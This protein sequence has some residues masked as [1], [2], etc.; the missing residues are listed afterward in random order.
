MVTA[1]RPNGLQ[2]FLARALGLERVLSLNEYGILEHHGVDLLGQS[3]DTALGRRTERSNAMVVSSSAAVFAAVRWREQAIVRPV[4]WLQQRRGQDWED[5]GTIEDSDAHPALAALHRVNDAITFRQGFG[6]VERGKLTNG[7]HLWLKRRD[8]LGVVQ[9]FETWSGVNVRAVPR[10]DRPWVPA[11]FERWNAD[12]SLTTVQPEDVIWFRHIVH[13]DNP[14]VS[15][16]P[17][18][19]IR[20]TVDTSLEAERYNQRYFDNG[21]PFGGLL[22]PEEAEGIG[23]GEAQRIRQQMEAEWKGTDNAHRWHLVEAKLKLLN[24]PMTNRDLEW[25]AL[26]KWGVI[27]VARAFELNPTTLKDFERA[28]YS[29]VDQAHADDWE[30]IQNQLDTTVAELN[31]WFIWPDFGT[32]LRLQARYDNIPALAEDQKL[33][34]EIDE[35]RLRAGTRSL[36][37]ILERDGLA[38]INGGGDIAGY[39]ERFEAV[40]S[41]IRSGYEPAAVLSVLGLPPIPHSGL[42]PVTVQP[43]DRAPASQAPPDQASYGRAVDVTP[44][45]EDEPQLLAAERRLNER[46]AALLRRELRALIDHIENASVRSQ[47]ILPDDAAES[48]AWDSWLSR[49]GPD[50]ER[51]LA[52]VFS[53]SLV[54]TA[55]PPI[56]SLSSLAAAYARSRASQ[57]LSLGTGIS[58][59]ETTRQAVREA[60]ARNIEAGQS[61]RQLKNDLRALHAFSADRAELIARTETATAAGQGQLQVAHMEGRDEK[62]W[63]VALDER[64][65]SLC[66]GNRADGWIGIDDSFSS[67]VDTVPA[68][69]RCRCTLVTRTRR[70]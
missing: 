51:A 18:G 36:N 14:M 68:H 11:R 5:V 13:P 64:V 52:A 69:G 44:Q 6:G 23:A 39:K 21:L 42:W 54:E 59:P 26:M 10:A 70:G 62:R 28:T 20:V 1:T 66:A 67:G 33:Q 9:E 32:D 12:G 49:Y 37:H 60:V 15:L 43:A 35:I 22:V 53:A 58:L 50:F 27:E 41:L 63:A 40:G 3:Y 8:R 24:T 19:A 7:H 45:T 29:N 57:L 25:A 16:T 38:T 17:I 30:T 34:A 47:R 48:Y 61:I 65:C 2:R 56:T 31:E 46:A 4:I 55:F